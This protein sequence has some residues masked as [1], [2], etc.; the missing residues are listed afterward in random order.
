[1]ILLPFKYMT[2]SGLLFIWSLLTWI[3]A[4]LVLLLEFPIL[5]RC[6]PTGSGLIKLGM[7]MNQSGSRAISYGILSLAEWLSLVVDVSWLLV[8]AGLLSAAALAW[9]IAL[10]RGESMVESMIKGGAP[11]TQATLG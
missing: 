11:S 7:I 1:M 8:P 9:L 3:M 2:G 10:W 4:M 5:G 6:L